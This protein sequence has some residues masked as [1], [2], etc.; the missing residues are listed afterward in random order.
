MNYRRSRVT[1]A[2]R[3]CSC[4]I[5]NIK[6]DRSRKRLNLPSLETVWKSCFAETGFL[7]EAAVDTSDAFTFDFQVPPLNPTK[8]RRVISQTAESAAATSA[9]GPAGATQT[10][11]ELSRHE[12]VD[13][14]IHAALD[15][16]KQSYDE[17][18][19]K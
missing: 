11:A 16:R 5:K 2:T 15:V 1:T 6:K 14:R 12:A 18:K 8:C 17:L 7:L 13:N 4:L 19:T 3:C 10:G 9:A